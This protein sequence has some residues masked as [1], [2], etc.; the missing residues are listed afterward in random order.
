MIIPIVCFTC[1][2]VLADKWKTYQEK[3]AKLE[4]SSQ[5]DHQKA[6]TMDDIS[7]TTDDKVEK[8]FDKLPTE[9]ILDDLGLTRQ[10]CRRHFLTHVD[11]IHMI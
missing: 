4:S 9:K 10:C 6:F 8:Y 2:K 7:I 11:L 1:N 3:V 5:R